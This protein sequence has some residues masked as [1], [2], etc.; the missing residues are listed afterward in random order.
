MTLKA[1]EPEAEQ[2]IDPGADPERV[3]E[4][5]EFTEG[6]VWSF[7]QDHLTFVDL[8]GNV[9]YRWDEASGTRVLRSP[10]DHANG[11]AYDSEGSLV[12]CEHRTR[13]ITRETAE[14]LVTLVDRYRGKRLNA[15]NDLVIGSDGTI[16]FTDPHY[17]LTEGYGGPGE[18]ELPFRGVYRLAPG[19]SE[20]ELVA[21]DFEGPNGLALTPDQGRLIVVDSERNHLR[22]FVVGEGW[23]FSG[24][25]VL[26]ELPD[27]GEG[28]P[29]G[30]KFDEA[31]NLFTTGPG[32]VWL[33]NPE[34]T[35]LGHLPMPEVT[36]NLAWGGDDCRTLYLT[37]STGLY[38][39]RCKTTGYAFH[40]KWGA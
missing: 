25:G 18:Q 4:G 19:S 27:E 1:F 2:L 29:D 30:L 14:G 31:G 26:A 5:F 12:S 17:G 6:P 22:A 38:R 8:A 11:L 39:L 9:M 23:L 7:R 36:A 20:P 21:D 10:S 15:P 3:A 37:A 16:I 40:R 28:V 13:R 33:C 35:I 34:G 32:G 24:G